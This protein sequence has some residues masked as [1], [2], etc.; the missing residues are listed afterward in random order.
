MCMNRFLRSL[1]IF[2]CVVFTGILAYSGYRLYDIMHTYKVSKDMYNQLSGQYVSNVAPSAS[3]VN[4][5]AS[6]SAS[7][8]DVQEK[9]ER[10][11]LQ[12]NFEQLQE[13]NG[14]VV[15]WIYG[16]GTVINYPVAHGKDNEY[17]L[18]NFIDGTY[19]GTGTPFVDYLCAGDF[20]EQNT[21]IYG[22]NMKDGSMFASLRKYRTEGYYEEHPILYLNTPSQNYKIEVFAGYV[23]DAESDSYIFSFSDD[24][25]YQ[26]FLNSWKAQ[27]DFVTPVEPSAQD[28]IVTL[29]TCTYEFFDARY[30][31]QGRLVPIG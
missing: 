16:P 28:R 21:V 20:S 17:Y 9:V 22:H 8:E 27:S 23:T 15:A 6:S 30:V 14:D 12:V 1:L 4:P 19:T 2:L 5:S 18:Y 29:S 24:G 13:A 25:D 7:S 31:V 11:P 26:R 3:P 10:S